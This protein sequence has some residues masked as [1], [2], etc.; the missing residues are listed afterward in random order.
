M[1]NDGFALSAEKNPKSSPLYSG[2]NSYARGDDEPQIVL[3]KSVDDCKQKLFNMYH[4]NY[5]ILGQRQ[6]LKPGILGGLFGQKEYYEVRYTIGQ[7]KTPS[8]Q[9]SFQKNRDEILN[10]AG[11]SV[12]NTI[13]IANIDKKLEEMKKTMEATM[14][15]IAA[16][17]KTGDKPLSIQKIEDLLQ[18][19]E[20]T[21]AYIN[22]ITTRLRSELSVEELEDF[23][24]VQKTVVDWIGE[25]IKVAPKLPHK[26][27]HVVIVVGPTGVGK[28]TTIAKFAVNLIKEAHEK[29][30][31]RP[32]VRMLTTDHTRVGAVEQIKRYGDVMEIE[33]DKAETAEEVKKIFDTYKD[34][35]DVLFIDTPGYSPKD[36]ENLG[37]MRKILE[38][39][40]IHPDVYLAATASSKARDLISIIQNYEV[41]NFSSVIITKWDETSAIGNVISV[42]SEKDK[43][44]SFITDGQTVTKNIERASVVRFLVNLH[45]FNIDR[46]HIDEKFPED[47]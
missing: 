34:S 46:K 32:R 44:V 16:A 40:G 47:K 23:D 39:N 42:L 3:G 31:P 27:P 28:T 38:V 26:Y 9:E 12:T 25:S 6:V 2:P 8:E 20:F 30:E 29:N 21:F 10:K 17:T 7:P 13:Q 43:A 22:K 35:L 4:H 37:K 15:N 19:N 14:K 36:F 1:Y 18:E 45:D 5:R 33:V 24:F 41:F 11:S